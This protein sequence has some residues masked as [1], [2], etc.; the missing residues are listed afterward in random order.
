MKREAIYIEQMMIEKLAGIINEED[1][2]YLDALI[3][4]NP[5]I[6][7]QWEEMRQSFDPREA[8]DYKAGLDAEGAWVHLKKEIEEKKRS[9]NAVS[10]KLAIAASLLIPLLMAAFFFF[11]SRSPVPESIAEAPAPDK[12][13]RL[14]VEGSQEINLSEASGITDISN[15][16]LNINS[17]G[18]SYEA[19]EDAS[20]HTLNTLVV[21]ETLTY[22]LSLPD[23]TEVWINSASKIKFPFVFPKDKRE[24][25]VEGE[26]YF[27]VAK[28]SSQPFIVHTTLT[29]IKVTGTEF[30]VNAYDSLRIKTSLVEGAV[31]AKSAEGKEVHIKP[32]YEATL[33]S[34]NEFNIAPFDG[35]NELAWMRGIYFFQNASVKEIANVIRRWYGNS[36]VFD[37]ATVSSSRFT[38]ALFKDRPLKEFLDN[39]M[40]TSN[41]NYQLSDGKIRLSVK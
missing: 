12:S 29:E 41:I 18:L 27:K 4:D 28:N 8:D 20:N 26:A 6:R 22:K 3:N 36:M 40:L 37:N 39:L 30:N 24:V 34:G 25:W 32:G 16:K 31:S 38:G 35:N 15:A 10:Y 9:R 11:R 17:E 5:E 21:P 14:F 13:I 7:M 19:K 2:K 23:G 33:R 1:R